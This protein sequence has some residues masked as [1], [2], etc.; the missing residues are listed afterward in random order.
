[1]S[2]KKSISNIAGIIIA[3]G[4]SMRL[5][6]AKQLLTWHGKSL[7]E[8]IIQIVTDCRLDPIHVV[9]GSNYNQIVPYINY[10]KVKIIN[11]EKWKEG[12][13]TSI[14]LG[15]RS[16]PEKVKATF[17]FVVDQPFLDQRLINALLDVYEKKNAD[18]VAPYVRGIQSNP[19]LFNKKVFSELMKLK[20]KEG[21]RDI[22]NN[23]RLERLSWK[24]EKNIMGYRYPC[25]L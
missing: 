7:I 24:D 19:V 15:V 21:G 10:P 12:K 13:G 11:N 22:F 17:I 8:F 20:G 4:E 16:L 18:I 14:S 9:L 25:R 2:S 3:A 1:M 23:F 6:R 5:G